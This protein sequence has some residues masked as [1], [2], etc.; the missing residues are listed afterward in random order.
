MK[1][2]LVTLFILGGAFAGTAFLFA[3]PALASTTRE[4]LLKITDSSTLKT[5]KEFYAFEKTFKGG[6]SMAV[7]DLGGD[8]VKEIIV[9]AGPYGGP[10]VRT[11]RLDGSPITNFYAYPE[12]F[13]GGIEIAT[14]DLDGDGQDEIITA[15]RFR[16]GAQVRIFDGAGKEKFTPGFFA[17]ATDYNGGIQ[18]AACDVDGNGK[19][20]IV[21]GSGVNSQPH[22]RVFDRY[23]KYTG[24]DF[25]PFNTTDQGGVSVACANVDG[26]TE[27]EIVMGIH[28]YGK[29]WVRVYKTNE[30]KTILGD[31]LSFPENFLGGVNVAGGDIDGDGLDEVLA[32]ANAGGGPQVRAFEGDGKALGLNFFAYETNF[33]GGVSVAAADIQGDSKAEIL[34]LPGRR[35]AEGRIDLA[36]YIEI[37]TEK[38]MLYYYENG[39]KIAEYPVSTGKPG[40]DTPH[41]NYK[42]LS[43]APLAYSKPYQ[44]YMPNW[45][46]FTSKGHGIHGL[47][48]WRLRG[49]GVYYEGENHL[50]RKVSHG[51]V[52]L[53]VPASKIVYDRVDVGTPVIVI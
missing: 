36:K 27:E 17:F 40:M 49:G 8:G 33:R 35:I 12:S 37:N 5:V 20:E 23:G 41:G 22:V 30:Q 6:G 50:G 34:T 28:A 53:P 45:M 15:P 42:V 19:K 47:P 48:F 32:G 16:G 13:Q 52:R 29:A 7:G 4:P 38:Q 18:V 44:L 25:R 21:V 46:A 43:K 24:L 39:I 10:Q 11:F 2:L 1:R 14:G 26:G 31:F 9:G 3:E 51:C